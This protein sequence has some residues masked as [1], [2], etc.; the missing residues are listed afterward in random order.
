[1]KGPPAPAPLALEF[2]MKTMILFVGFMAAGA[3]ASRVKQPSFR[4]TSLRCTVPG[5]ESAITIQSIKEELASSDSNAIRWR[6]SFGFAGV[7]S[8]RVSVVTDSV[9]C[10]RITAV[11]DSTFQTTP[12]STV[13]LAVLRVGSSRF[14]AFDTA[15]Q[16]HWYVF[17][18]TYALA[19]VI[20]H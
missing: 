4:T 6:A 19:H 20:V 3:A 12:P 1:V 14:V 11:A 9:A 18:R 17:D 13:A 7:D 10:T 2:E 15:T 5:A 8:S 16:G